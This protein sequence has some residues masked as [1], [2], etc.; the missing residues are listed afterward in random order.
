MTVHRWLKAEGVYSCWAA[1]KPLL[2]TAHIEA[3]LKFANDHSGFDFSNVVFSDEK[4][5]RMRPGGR[6]RVWRRRG[7]RYDAK[8]VVPTVARTEGVM[9]WAAING[10][11]DLIVKRCPTTVDSLGYQSIL[12]SA[13]HFIRGRFSVSPPT[14]AL[15][16][17]RHKDSFVPARR[18]INTSKPVHE[19]LVGCAACH[20]VKQ[21][22]VACT[23]TGF[24][25]G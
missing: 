3:R 14:A 10:K 16:Q 2:T 25:P 6:V 21:W 17:G 19:G 22:C 20:H 9:V 1:G 18:R 4:V 13:R 11:G 7:K 8:Y 24:E 5:W 15:P 12:K 23:F